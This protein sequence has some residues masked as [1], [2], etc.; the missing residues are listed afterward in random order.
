[1]SSSID[2]S[3]ITTAPVDKAPFKLALDTARDE[4]TAIHE[5]LG[6]INLIDNASLRI[7]QRGYTS[8]TNVTGSNAYTLDR[9]RVVTNGQNVSWTTTDG[10]VTATVPAGGFEQ[11]IEGA[12]IAP[13]TYVLNW[14]GTATATVNSSPVAKGALV[15]LTGNVNATLRF[16]N[17][18]LSLPVM[19]RRTATGPSTT[20]FP[21]L[22][23]TL[24][25]LICQ[26]YALVLRHSA[27]G[28]IQLGVGSYS[29]SNGIIQ[30]PFRLPVRMRANPAVTFGGAWR[31]YGGAATAL[32]TATEVTPDGF[33][34]TSVF[35]FSTDAAAIGVQSADGATGTLTCSADL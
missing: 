19:Q 12:R 10:V 29:L 26:R 21:W 14:T 11:V 24:D 5:A 18:T 2:T 30:G 34:W 4:I 8:G 3:F 31:V 23:P 35:S 20:L 22:H 13:G 32:P 25:L 33:F 27:N 15:S 28:R 7:N 9:W 16:S 6:N 17:G 1:M